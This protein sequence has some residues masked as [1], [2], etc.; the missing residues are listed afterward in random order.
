MPYRAKDIYRGRRKF[1]VPLTIFLFILAGLIIGA[2]VLFYVLQQYIIY[3]Q[4]GVTLALPFMQAETQPDPELV[5][6]SPTFEPIAVQVIYEEPDFNEIDLSGWDLLTDTK[7]RFIPYNDVVS[8][9]KL[10]SDISNASGGDFTG[11]VFELKGRSGRL[12]WA[13]DSELASAY[14]TAGTMDY[15]ELV[16]SLHEQGYTCA[17]QI[18]CCADELMATRNWPVTLQQ[19]S[20]TPYRDS[21]GVYWLDPYNRTVRDYIADLMAEL[22]AMGFDEIVL[23]DLCHPIGAA[24]YG[25]DGALISTGFQY[26]VTLQTEESPV[27]AVCQ[28]ARRLAEGMEDTGT[29]V[30]VLL[31][32][33][34]L[35]NGSAALTGQEIDIFW[36]VFARLYCPCESWNA[37]TDLETAAETLNGGDI[38]VRFV[39]VCEYIPEDFESYL[40]LPT[41]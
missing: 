2:V 20:G 25:E 36:R 3:D 35:R 31:D 17:A 39:P 21:G 24:S 23:A 32:E 4:N 5:E 26:S 18:S 41:K 11:F 28:M 30:S 22:S 13:S 15:T 34:S 1:H 8:E 19:T 9:T 16:A 10:A 27:N 37:M 29:T 38:A 12:A 7:A 14:G 6:P 40:L 33:A